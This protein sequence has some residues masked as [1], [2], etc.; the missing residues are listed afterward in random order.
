M[1][2]HSTTKCSVPSLYRRLKGLHNSRP[3][4]R[5]GASSTYIVG[6]YVP[7]HNKTDRLSYDYGGQ[8]ILRGKLDHLLIVH[9]EVINGVEVLCLHC[10][11]TRVLVCILSW[12]SRSFCFLYL[13]HL[14]FDCQNV[15]FHE[16]LF[17]NPLDW[18]SKLVGDRQYVL[19]KYSPVKT[20]VVETSFIFMSGDVICYVMT[21]CKVSFLLRLIEVTRTFE[22]QVTTMKLSWWWATTILCNSITRWW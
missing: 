18:C 5:A 11:T 20:H 9:E 12:F 13:L 14:I 7:C 2:W 16:L 15:L 4:G 19:S 6:K 10:R 17:H 3:R 22:S 1:P 21:T 8:Y